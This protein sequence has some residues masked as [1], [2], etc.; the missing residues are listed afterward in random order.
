MPGLSTNSETGKE[1]KHTVLGVLANSEYTSYTTRVYPPCLPAHPRVY[2]Y[3]SLHTLGY[4]SWYTPRVSLLVYTLGILLVH[5]L[6]IPLCVTPWVYL[7]V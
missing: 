4:P 2:H 5:T 7:P 3:A 1:E 6:G